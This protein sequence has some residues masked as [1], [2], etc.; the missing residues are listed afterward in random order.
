M[1]E[2]LKLTKLKIKKE[3]KKMRGIVGGRILK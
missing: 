1:T 3:R 2:N